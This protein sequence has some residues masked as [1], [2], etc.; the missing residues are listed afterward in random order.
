MN[1]KEQFD[2]QKKNYG[3]NSITEEKRIKSLTNRLIESLYAPKEGEKEFVPDWP[4]IEALGIDR[5]EPINWGDLGCYSVEL[6]N[7]IY[8]VIID[9]ADPDNCQT[10]CDYIERHLKSW[11]W[12]V[13]VITEW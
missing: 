13:V 11:G 1:N 10:F 9:E 3:D 2:F 4:R 5:L 8:L 6:K 7:N 12:N